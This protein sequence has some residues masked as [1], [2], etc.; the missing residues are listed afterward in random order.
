MP[1]ILSEATEGDLPGLV[2]AQYAAFHPNDTMHRLIYPSPKIPTQEVIDKTVARQLKSWK[3]NPH[4]TWLKITDSETG[5]IAA[6]AKWI[7][8]PHAEE[9]EDKKRW[10]DKVDVNW[11][12]PATEGVNAGPGADDQEYVEWALEQFFDRRRE[13]VNGPCVLLDIC[14]TH[15]EFHRRGAG[16]QLVEWGTRRADELGV[17]GYV[18]AS[19]TGRWLYET[20]GFKPTEHVLLEA[21]KQREEWKEYE[22]VGYYFMERDARSGP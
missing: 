9:V 10:P 4:V 11:V 22:Q 14:F 21:G 6:G 13:R 20:C 1:L 7:V 2:K 12:G 8:W 3:S 5:T 16:K 15:P 19:Y 18:E 17:K